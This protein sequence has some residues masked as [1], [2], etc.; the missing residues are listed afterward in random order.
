MLKH[1]QLSPFRSRADTLSLSSTASYSS[2]N[3]EPLSS[4]SSSYSSLSEASPSR[5]AVITLS[6]LYG[7][8]PQP[9]RTNGVAIVFW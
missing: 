9:T 2:L 3:P 6:F 5:S 4:R 8:N 1:V 7:I